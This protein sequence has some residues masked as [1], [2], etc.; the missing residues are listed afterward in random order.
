MDWRTTFWEEEHSGDLI[1]VADID[2][3]YCEIAR[4][5]EGVEHPVFKRYAIML[6]D[7]FPETSR[8]LCTDDLRK[9]QAIAEVEAWWDDIC[10]YAAKGWVET[11]PRLKLEIVAERKTYWDLQRFRLTEEGKRHI[12]VAF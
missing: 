4:V 12:S 9:D 1:F 5:S 6:V 8:S 3:D 2:G 11:I 7:G 10:S